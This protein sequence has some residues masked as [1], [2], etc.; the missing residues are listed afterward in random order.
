M[1]LKNVLIIFIISIIISLTPAVAC[2]ISGQNPIQNNLNNN[3]L[4]HLVKQPNS[5]KSNQVNTKK[6]LKQQR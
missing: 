3:S 2:E 4:N 6:I 1:N 5:N